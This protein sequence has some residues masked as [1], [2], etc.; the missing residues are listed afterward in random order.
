MNDMLPNPNAFSHLLTPSRIDAFSVALH[1]H[2]H[3]HKAEVPPF[4]KMDREE[5]T[6]ACILC[7]KVRLNRAPTTTTTPLH[8]LLAALERMLQAFGQHFSR[9][10]VTSIVIVIII[11]IVKLV[12]YDQPFSVSMLTPI[13]RFT[14]TSLNRT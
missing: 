8:H 10:S 7:V 4:D 1:L 11:D 6:R 14:V 2:L 9:R 5:F 3:L 12:R 13:L